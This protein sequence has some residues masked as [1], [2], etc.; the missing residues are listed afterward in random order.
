MKYIKTLLIAIV[1]SLGVFAPLSATTVSALDPAGEALKGVNQSGGTGQKALPKT[2]EIVV[3]LLFFI[4]GVI[5]VIMLI[6]GG[7]KFTTSNGDS[8]QIKSAKD[9]I[10]YAIIGLVVALL[11]YAIVRFVLQQF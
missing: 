6:V 10:L 2:I 1:L 11:A 7:I 8:G 3:N 4:L 9:T 5:A